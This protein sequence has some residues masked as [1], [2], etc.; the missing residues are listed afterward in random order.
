M[1]QITLNLLQA[2]LAHTDSYNGSTDVQQNI[3]GAKPSAE[4]E[5]KSFF[6]YFLLALNKGQT[7]LK[8]LRATTHERPAK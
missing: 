4:I 8:P 6:F 2:K 1:T 5:H 3:G 7:E